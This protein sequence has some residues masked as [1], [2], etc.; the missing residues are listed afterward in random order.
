MKEW[1]GWLVV[2]VTVAGQKEGNIYKH[3]DEKK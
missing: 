1:F 3:D 2:V